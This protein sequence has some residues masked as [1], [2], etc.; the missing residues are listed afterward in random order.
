M[1]R[2]RTII[3]DD[4]PLARKRVRTLL[5]QEPDID[6]V[7]ECGDGPET[8]QAMLEQRPDLVLLDIQM[9]GL[10]GFQVL[11]HIDARRR[12][13]II[14]VTAYDQHALR[15]FEASAT[16]YL[17]KPFAP[18]RFHEALARVRRQQSDPALLS[19][20]L[21]AL[22]RQVGGAADRPRALCVRDGSKWSV[23]PLGEIDWIEAAGKHVR[24]H[25]AARAALLRESIGKLEL[26]L[27]A[28]QFVRI[29]RSTIVNIDR[30]ASLEP[31]FHGDMI[32]TLRGG[33]T[34]TLSR[35]Y[36]D[37]LRQA[38]GAL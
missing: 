28:S 22:L 2:L 18:E 12:P 5:T 4:E 27:P 25:C 24:L 34:L 16:D 31:A 13:A 17:L 36:R 7:A 10:D 35:A 1:R 11:E 19:R 20:Q 33:A 21:E 37:R 15:A 14:F 32:V 6:I 3:A 9:P 26:R 23:I 38:I 30:I 8:L 29:H